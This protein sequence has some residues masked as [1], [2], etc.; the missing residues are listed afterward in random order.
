[1]ASTTSRL[2][3]RLNKFAQF[4]SKSMTPVSMKTLLD[5]GTG[6]L[7]GKSVSHADS[8][9]MDRSS[10]QAK[11]VQRL[12]RLQ[13]ASFLRREI[14]IR[15]SHRIRDLETLPY[16]LSQMKAIQGVQNDYILSC[17]EVLG[18]PEKF[19]DDADFRRMVQHIYNRHNDTLVEVARGLQEFQGSPMSKG[20]AEDGKDLSSL[21]DI[22]QFLDRFFLSRIGIR[23]LLG[24]YLEVYDH[25]EHSAEKEKAEGR[26]DYV[27][28]ICRKTSAAGV[29]EAAARDAK[30]M[31]DRQYGDSPEVEIL[32][33]TDLTFAYIPSHLY[34]ILFEL[35][36]NSMRAVAEHHSKAATLPEIRVIVADGEANEDVAIKISDLGGGI[37]RSNMRKIFSYL[38][39]TAGPVS[40]NLDGLED[41]GRENPLAGLGYGLPI[42]RLYLQYFGGDLEL[43]SMEG[44]GT[45]SFVHLSRLTD[46]EEPLP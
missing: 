16:G 18:H 22:H 15:L 37:P 13:I 40:E 28:I 42:S 33:R 1:M 12:A 24:H 31:C 2:S 30:Y 25:S 10:H 32:G 11:E 34:Y 9:Y 23:V 3:P 7:L 21:Q 41:F 35:L 39:T 45:D 36:K 19:E 44:H 43:K 29:V 6:N 17:E 4:Y 8:Y 27:G 46:N 14:P 20:L 26:E 5:S 38:F